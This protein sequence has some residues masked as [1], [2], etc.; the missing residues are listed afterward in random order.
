MDIDSG[1]N[2]GVRSS[3]RRS[4]CGAAVDLRNGSRSFAYRIP[5]TSSIEVS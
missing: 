2:T 1:T 3:V 5:T 4:G